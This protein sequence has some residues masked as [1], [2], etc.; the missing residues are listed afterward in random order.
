VIAACATPLV[1]ALALESGP[2]N[3]GAVSVG[4]VPPE[5]VL[6]EQLAMNAANINTTPIRIEFLNIEFPPSCILKLACA[7]RL[8]LLSIKM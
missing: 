3:V 6:F 5:L 8:N 7:Q 2:A 1:S 4:A